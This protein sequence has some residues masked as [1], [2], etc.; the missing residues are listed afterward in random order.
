[1]KIIDITGWVGMTIVLSGYFLISAGI[2]NS[3]MIL[4]HMIVIIGCF[5]LIILNS[6]KKIYQSVVINT[7]VMCFSIF[8]IIRLIFFK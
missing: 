6:Y 3:N 2:L 5:L 4:Y 8:A 1:M 7:T